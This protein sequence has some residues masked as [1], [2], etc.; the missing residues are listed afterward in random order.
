[1]TYYE[2]VI[3]Y[4][5]VGVKSVEKVCPTCCGTNTESHPFMANSD[6]DAITKAEERIGILEYAYKS[7]C[8]EWRIF[9]HHL[10]NKPGK[11]ACVLVQEREGTWVL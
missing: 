8:C 9:R 5:L 11:S 1:M 10:S 6:Q 2:L 3:T 4:P 7:A